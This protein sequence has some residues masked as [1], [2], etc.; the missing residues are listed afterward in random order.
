MCNDGNN[1]HHCAVAAPNDSEHDALYNMQQR[2]VAA[3][4]ECVIAVRVA[5]KHIFHHT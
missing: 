2:L 1:N 3:N 5:F 4:L